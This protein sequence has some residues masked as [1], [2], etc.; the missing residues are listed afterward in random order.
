MVQSFRSDNLSIPQLIQLS[1]IPL[2]QPG[3]ICF[4]PHKT[5]KHA[6][7]LLPSHSK[8]WTTTSP[9][10]KQSTCSHSAPQKDPPTLL[11]IPSI[12][13]NPLRPPPTGSK[14]WRKP[15]PLPLTHG[16]SNPDGTP[17]DAISFD[18]IC[19]QAKNYCSA[20]KNTT[21]TNVIIKTA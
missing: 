6:N 13:W 2:H 11:Y 15:Q 19:A 21:N 3:P 4:H 7:L 17:F 14:C 8:Q 20:G 1:T 9:T 18:P 12:H 10:P 5:P 16:Y